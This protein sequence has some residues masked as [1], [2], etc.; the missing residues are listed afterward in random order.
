MLRK[1][2]IILT[3]ITFGFLGLVIAA[4][5]TAPEVADT[6]AEAEAPTE[7]PLTWAER[8]DTPLEN[9]EIAAPL[10]MCQEFV[11]DR[12]KAP[13]TAE[14]PWSFDDYQTNRLVTHENAYNIEGH[15]DSQNSF[16]AM[17][18]SRFTCKI[19]NTVIE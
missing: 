1:I 19:Q 10:T 2:L 18:R 15:V 13:S 3:I 14:F 11:K 16:G 7:T 4:I 8:L 17:L 5:A 9:E 6:E 12:L